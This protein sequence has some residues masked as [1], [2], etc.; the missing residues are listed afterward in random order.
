[1]TTRL[2]V[3]NAGSAAS[4]NL[5]RSLRA[6][7]ASVFILGCHDDQFVLKNSQAD[8]NYLTPPSGHREWLRSLLRIL[9]TERI[10]LLIPTTD[11]DVATV[12]RV[13]RALQGRLLLPRP[14]AVQLCQ[15]K[16]RL[17]ARLRAR[18]IPAPATYPVRDLKDIPRIF[19]QL[20]RA[21]TVWCRIRTGAG[22]IG[23]IPVSS[24]KQARGWIE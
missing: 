21:S 13:R 6:G 24:P 10:D 23:A 16:Y 2:L 20:G 4:N 15:D 17:I 19:R 22:A 14:A 3:T 8:R 5:V 11:A 9:R 1:M 12:S 7:D 18:G